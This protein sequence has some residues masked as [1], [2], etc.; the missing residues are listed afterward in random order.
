MNKIKDCNIVFDT[1]AYRCLSGGKEE[2]VRKLFEDLANIEKENRINSMSQP[3]V[4]MELL[5][6]LADT[7]DSY[8]DICKKALI[9]AYIHCKEIDEYPP[10]M[11]LDFDVHLC[12][13][14]FKKH[15]EKLASLEQ[16]YGRIA[17]Q[18]YKDSSDGNMEKLRNNFVIVAENRKNLKQK[19]IDKFINVFNVKDKK[20]FDDAVKFGEF[21]RIIASSQIEKTL[22]YMELDK[23]NIKKDDYEVYLDK[24]I[25]KFKTPLILFQTFIQKAFNHYG[26]MNVEK[27]ANTYFDFQILFIV[28]D[29]TINQKPILLVT[30]DKEMID[31]SKELN[32]EDK[33][34]KLD[35]YLKEIG[36][37]S[38]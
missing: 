17:Y 12:E 9:G 27:R 4:L 22:N 6:H 8:Y 36:F 20:E 19:F 38:H 31:A 32:C 21:L 13:L 14:L 30:N 7:A 25:E 10:R 28:G 23:S 24:V 37:Q 35:N 2:K 34:I 33:I 5:S 3:V 16:S 15:T 18:V 1:N 29:H 11:L 26:D